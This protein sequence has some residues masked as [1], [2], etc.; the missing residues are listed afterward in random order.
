MTGK[1][2]SNFIWEV[3]ESINKG[4]LPSLDSTYIWLKEADLKYLI[5]SQ[6]SDFKSK[7]E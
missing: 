3:V 2:Y 6:I 1:I 7:L 5:E 4:I